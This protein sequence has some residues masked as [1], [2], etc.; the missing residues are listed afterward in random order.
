[1]RL[2]RGLAALLCAAAL[3]ALAEAP[4]FGLHAGLAAP[5]SDLKDMVDSR[6]GLFLGGH[7]LF[8]LGQGLQLRPRVEYLAFPEAYDRQ[9]VTGWS[10]GADALYYLK[11]HT[12]QGVYLAAGLGLMAWKAEVDTPLGTGSET[13]HKLAVNAGAGYQFNNLF[14]LEGRYVVS[15]IWDDDA[16]MFQAVATFRF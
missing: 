3:P 7:V 11:G 9:T 8:D 16:G 2:V 10:V 13:T 6:V 4:R 1:M 12:R 14:G 15:K 5:Q